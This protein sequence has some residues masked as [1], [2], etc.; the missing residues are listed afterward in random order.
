MA[1]KCC[2]G[3]RRR[4]FMRIG[5]LAGLSLAEILRLRQSASAGDSKRDDVNCIFVFLIGGMPHQDMWD[6]KPNAP[7][8]IRGDFKPISTTVP[9]IQFGDVIPGIAQVA[10]KLAVLRS[11][12]HV[13]SD[14]RP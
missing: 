8:G 2:D 3:I 14:L 4:E 12:T 9:G 1:F 10:D 6:L 5:S 13:D 11:M 7:V